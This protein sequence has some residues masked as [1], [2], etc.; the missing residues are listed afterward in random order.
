MRLV[1]REEDETGAPGR[2]RA[3]S[4]FSSRR[5]LLGLVLALGLVVIL[6]GEARKPENWRWFERVTSV[7]RRA[8][9][10]PP[11]P[12]KNEELPGTFTSRPE[13]ATATEEGKTSERPQRKTQPQS[14][15]PPRVWFPGL[16]AEL[17][18]TVRDNRRF[19]NEEKDAWFHLFELLRETPEKRL[20]DASIGRVTR[21]QLF[22]QPGSYRGDLVETV[23]T[24]RRAHRVAATKNELGFEYL[25]QLWLQSEDDRTG[26]IVVYCLDLPKDFPLGME[27]N[28]PVSLVGFSFKRWAYASRGGLTMAP[29]LL[30]KTV[31]WSP[32]PAAK[33]TAR[34]P[35]TWD[36]I[37]LMILTALVL[38][39]LVVG[40][41]FWHSRREPRRESEPPK[42]QWEEIE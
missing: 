40:W 12:E 21:L 26:P 16:R 10:R 15:T 32:I 2:R 24:V 42:E 25:H 39:A 41:I 3:P 37:A 1:H 20:R 13:S 17:L 36:E 35:I 22:E 33:E 14:D 28:E 4:V 23:G 29:V 8:P 31:R 27:I 19:L 7:Q 38:S 18:K 30:A 6:F 34:G 5:R 11:T 9:E